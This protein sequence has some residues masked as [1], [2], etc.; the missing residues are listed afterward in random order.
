MSDR[1]SYRQFI[2]LCMART[3][4]RMLVQALNSHPDIRCFDEIFN[5]RLPYVAYGVWEYYKR[6]VEDMALRSENPARFLDERIFCEHPEGTQAVGFKAAYGHVSEFP[7]VVEHLRDN[8]ELHVIHLKRRNLLRLLTSIKIA[9]MT[10][11]WFEGDSKAMLRKRLTARNVLQAARHPRRAA[12]RLYQLWRGPDRPDRAPTKI[13]VDEFKTFIDETH[14]RVSHFDSLFH[15]HPLITV[16][17]EDLADRRQQVFDQV[18]K[19]LGVKTRPFTTTLRRQNPE[20]L[21]DLISNYDELYEAF[22][23]GL[24]E[25]FFEQDA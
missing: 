22:R 16:H 12:A 23:G 25:T 1:T 6:R 18:Q 2:I 14:S 11:V 10:G 4:S 3:G 5:P 13:S 21:N 7:G 9:E 8:R 17:Y 15:T 20:P 19:F 24:Y